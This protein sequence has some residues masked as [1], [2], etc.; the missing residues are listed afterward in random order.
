MEDLSVSL[1]LVSVFDSVCPSLWL[2]LC[3]CM[4]LYVSLYVASVYLCV[5]LCIS[6]CVP[7]FLCVYLWLYVCLRMCLC[8]FV[9]IAVG[10]P[11]NG[12]R[13]RRKDGKNKQEANQFE[14]CG[15]LLVVRCKG[16]VVEV[17]P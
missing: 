4:C 7:G 8:V 3:V 2:Y 13:G 10:K 5:P 14:R 1:S 6:M 11:E 15:F 16:L 12:V 17:K 9:R